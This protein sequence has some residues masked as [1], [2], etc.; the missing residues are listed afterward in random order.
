MHTPLPRAHVVIIDHTP[1]IRALLNDFLSEECYRVTALAE[2]LDPASLSALRPDVVLHDFTPET[3]ELDLDSMQRLIA[4]CRT[5]TVPLVLCSA[6]IDI[7]RVP[8]VLRAPNLRVV[9]KP[10]AL[11]DILAAVGA[12][13]PVTL[14]SSRTVAD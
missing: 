13:V 1:D 2:P 5:A 4:D 9:R 10:F 3:A 14:P 7:D 6:S 11:E 12:P 8:A